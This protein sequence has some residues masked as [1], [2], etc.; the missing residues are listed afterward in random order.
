MSYNSDFERAFMERSLVLVKQYEG[1]YDATLLLNCLLGLLVV[2]NE[3]C[4]DSIPAD[5]IDDSRKWGISLD[6]IQDRGTSQGVTNDPTTLRGLVKRLRNAVAHSRFEPDPPR[7]EVE[8]F[9]FH[10]RNGF[11]ARVELSELR[12]FVE[13]LAEKLKEM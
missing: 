13:K 10:D 1:P 11:R 4:V 12:E 3:R 6:A 5:P 9:C 8:A 2:P 7:G